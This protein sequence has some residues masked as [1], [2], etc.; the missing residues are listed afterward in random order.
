LNYFKIVTVS[1]QVLIKTLMLTRGV[2]LSGGAKI[3]SWGK[4]D[5]SPWELTGKANTLP[6]P[7]AGSN[8]FRVYNINFSIILQMPNVM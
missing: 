3:L 5:L 8:L 2:I 1:P 7:K 4:K 6:A